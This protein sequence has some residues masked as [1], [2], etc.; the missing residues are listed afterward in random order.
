MSSCFVVTEESWHASKPFASTNSRSPHLCQ[1]DTAND[2][3]D[4]GGGCIIEGMMTQ[5]LGDEPV[6]PINREAELTIRHMRL[7]AAGLNVHSDDFVRADARS[8]TSLAD[9]LERSLNHTSGIPGGM[10][11][12]V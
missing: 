5:Q 9:A 6:L 3:H 11:N 2:L 12:S 10:P 4:M 7:I 1:I 8:L